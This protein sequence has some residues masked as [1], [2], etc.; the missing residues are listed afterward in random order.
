[1][2]TGDVPSYI[3]ANS[4]GNVN[5]ALPVLIPASSPVDLYV[6]PQILH[7]SINIL[8]YLACPILCLSMF[9]DKNSQHRGCRNKI[10][11]YINSFELAKA[12]IHASYTVLA[13]LHFSFLAIL[14]HNNPM[15]ACM[16][17]T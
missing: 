17:N 12:F 7:N 4:V 16:W 15:M 8:I 6:L 10:R 13:L 3:T 11:R 9:I 2:I 5:R 14:D 1:M